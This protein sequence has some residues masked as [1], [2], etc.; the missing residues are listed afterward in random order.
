MK[1][2][3]MYGSCG[4]GHQRAAEYVAEGLKQR[5]EKDVI[6]VDF[7]IKAN[8]FCKKFYPWIY[9]YSVTHIAWLWGIGF[10][11]TNIKCLYWFICVLRRI[12]NSINAPGLVDFIITENP[13][14]I[15][16]THF[17]P[18]EVSAALKRS[19]KI[20]ATIVTIVTDSI[21]HVTWINRGTDY[22]I[23]LAEE[24]KKALIDWKV[25]EEAIKP[26]GI[27]IS[28]KFQLQQKRKFYRDNYGLK[29]DVFTVL[30]ASGSFGMGPIKKLVSLLN[31]YKE[32]IQ[33]MVVCGNNKV[34]FENLRS[35]TYD[36][37]VK[38]FPF[39]DFMDELMESADIIITKS[40][41]LTTCESM[42]KGLPMVIT[43]PIPGQ[44][45]YNAHFMLSHEA[46]FRIYKA[47]EIVAIVDSI[48][49]D[50]TLLQKKINNIL[51]IQKPHATKDIV[52]FILSLT[53]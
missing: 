15:I 5:G 38:V 3:L 6:I 42:A 49:A 51:S 19:K 44:E 31:N 12:V 50:K 14:V 47:S 43:K 13:D 35:K 16:L 32:K 27:P 8:P 48:V 52:D 1:Y 11:L 21:P 29:Q 37:T 4:H 2:L 46:S 53:T 40:G 33:V 28:S 18:A 10:Y 34:L 7:L 26:L 25:A 23:G 41:G 17:F 20:K 9:K 24:T 22:Y 39:V 36:C 45:T 30:I